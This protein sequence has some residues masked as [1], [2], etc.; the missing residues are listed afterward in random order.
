MKE[1]NIRRRL[2][3]SYLIVG[4]LNLT[5]ITCFIYYL[6]S[7]RRDLILEKTEGLV[8]SVRDLTISKTKLSLEKQKLNASIMTDEMSGNKP[9][10]FEN[11]A[12]Q[13]VWKLKGSQYLAVYGNSKLPKSLPS[14]MKEDYFYETS[15]NQYLLKVKRNQQTYLW[16]YNSGIIDDTKELKHSLGKSGAAYFVGSDRKIKASSR[17]IQEGATNINHDAVTIAL[18]NKTGS[19][20]VYDHKDVEVMSCYTLLQ[21]DDIKLVVLIDLEIEKITSQF[22]KLLGN[23]FLLCGSLVG[24][25]FIFSLFFARSMSGK[26]EVLNKEIQELNEAREKQTNE[27]AIQ[28]FKVQEEEREKISFT[29][30]DSVGQYLTVLRWGLTNLRVKFPQEKDHINNLIKTCD[31]IIHEIRCI[32]HDL[33]P[34][35]IK[36]FGCIL[37]I[38]DYVE[39]QKQIVPLDMSF[40]YPLELEGIHFRREFEINLYR[41]VQE[42][43]QNTLKHS[44][45]D[46][47]KLDFKS[48]PNSIELTY[49]DNGRGMPKKSQLPASLN[50]RAKLFGGEMT[51]V[52][53]DKGLGFKITFSLKDIGHE[54]N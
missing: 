41:M 1:K 42:F 26:V 30:H 52:N 3:L 49:Y 38:K 12:I 22:S 19:K 2:L 33:M 18:E 44:G 9:I 16:I 51:R 50:Y 35:L 24:M 13:S 10:S 37:A 36:D 47:V 7:N 28:V 5:I 29:L 6:Y 34:T 31:D 25:N 8:S 23:L 45:A 54:T 20:I 17:S 15:E 21:F 4:S 53:Y 39:K 40:N 48:L 14:P 27:S 43:F 32:S 46:Q 11:P